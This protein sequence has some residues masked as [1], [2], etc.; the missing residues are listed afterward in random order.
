LGRV[1]KNKENKSTQGDLCYVNNAKKLAP[2]FHE[3]LVWF[4]PQ[5]FTQ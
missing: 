5:F 1:L 2:K 3:A 4:F